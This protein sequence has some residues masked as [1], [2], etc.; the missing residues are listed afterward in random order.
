M[1]GTLSSSMRTEAAGPSDTLELLVPERLPDDGRHPLTPLV[2]HGTDL[3][4]LLASQSVI[5]ASAAW[6]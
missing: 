5:C 2:T 1:G 6:G 3:F 4:Q